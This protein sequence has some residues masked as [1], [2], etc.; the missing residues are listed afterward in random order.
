MK[1]IREALLTVV[2]NQDTIKLDRI[3]E[4][5]KKILKQ[6]INQDLSSAEIEKGLT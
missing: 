3:I 6:E 1:S 2:K 4:K 5:S